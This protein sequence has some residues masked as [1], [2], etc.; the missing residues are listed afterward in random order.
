MKYAVLAMVAVY[1]IALSISPKEKDKTAASHAQEQQSVVESAQ[2]VQPERLTAAHV[3]ADEQHVATPAVAKAHKSGVAEEKAPA[4]QWEA[5]AQSATQNVLALM[6]GEA[7]LPPPEEKVVAVKEKAVESLAVSCPRAVAQTGHGRPAASK[8][9]PVVCPGAKMQA[10]SGT[11]DI[12]AAMQKL[13]DATDDMVAVTRQLVGATQEMLA[14]SQEVA[15]EVIDSGK[16]L[17]EDK[18]AQAAAKAKLVEAVQDVVDATKKAYEA[19]SEALSGA[20]Q[21]K[22]PQ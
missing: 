18:E 21:G 9:C 6:N 16:G 2:Q 7:T 13:A 22:T 20:V 15:V 4:N 5:L 14:A 11:P 12:D 8:P 17:L 10:A 19:T 3:A 1:I